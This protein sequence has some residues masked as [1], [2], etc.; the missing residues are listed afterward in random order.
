VPLDEKETLRIEAFS[1]G[2]FAIAITLLVLDLKVPRPG[3]LHG[4]P[5]AQKLS[6][7]WPAL[8]AYLTSFVTILVMWVNHHVMFERIRRS[9]HVFMYLNGFLLLLVTFVPF[10]TS[11]VATYIHESTL[12][13]RDART[14]GLLYAGTYAVIAFAFN[15]LWHYAARGRRLVD[16][17]IPENRI[18]EISWQYALGMPLYLAACALAF[19]SVWASVALCL[20]MAVFFAFTGTLPERFWK[21]VVP[22]A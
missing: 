10:P 20:L 11:M 14:A 17:H 12:N 7:E 1:D 21:K 4:Q 18:R 22:R 6:E 5:L 16:H 2:V 9:D 15:V 19:F 8:L 3:E 13:P